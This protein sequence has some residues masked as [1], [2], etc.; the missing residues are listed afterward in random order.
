MFWTTTCVLLY[1][2]YE[3][4]GYL[5][6]T[7]ADVHIQK[8]GYWGYYQGSRG[9]LDG[10]PCWQ[11]GR[12]GVVGGL[13]CVVVSVPHTLS[14]VHAEI[15]ADV[16]IGKRR[17]LGPPDGDSCFR[18]GRWGAFRDGD[19]FEVSIRFEGSMT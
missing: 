11:D 7:Q 3:S 14:R 2:P 17:L 12:Q 15:Q 19:C 10:A 4:V 6:D 16:Q 1:V 13:L 8:R 18:E 9:L 5:T